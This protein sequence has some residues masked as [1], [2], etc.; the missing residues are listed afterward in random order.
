MGKK[1]RDGKKELGNQCQD[2]PKRHAQSTGGI[3]M[4]ARK[5]S[6]RAR[7]RNAY[8]IECNQC[9]NAHARGEIDDEAPAIKKKEE[10][11]EKGKS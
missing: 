9:E 6:G 1:G 4:R 7:K 11:E 10:H 3:N 8:Q 5:E 2:E